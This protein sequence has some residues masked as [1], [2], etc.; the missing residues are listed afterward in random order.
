MQAERAPHVP[1]S[2]LPCDLVPKHAFGVLIQHGIVLVERHNRFLHMAAI[3]LCKVRNLM[4]SV[5]ENRGHSVGSCKGG[6]SFHLR[7]IS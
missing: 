3:T 1:W 6:C 5:M 2:H 4:S 7:A